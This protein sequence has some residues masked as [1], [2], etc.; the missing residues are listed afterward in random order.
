M[1]KSNNDQVTEAVSAKATTDIKEKPTV[2]KTKVSKTPK[3]VVGNR[4][5]RLIPNPKRR[6]NIKLK[7]AQTKVNSAGMALRDQEGRVQKTL[8]DI[9]DNTIQIPGTTRT[10][11]PSLGPSGLNTGLSTMVDNPYSDEEMYYPEEFERILKGK[12]KVL[13]QHALEYKHKKSIGY[14][15]NRLIDRINPSDKTSELP[16]F[17]T[18]QCQIP[19]SGGVMFLD[20]SNQVHEVWLYTLLASPDIANSYKML[21]ETPDAWY[22]IEDASE[23]ISGRTQRKR[24]ENK[25][26]AALE[27]VYT[28]GNNMI[29]KWAKCLGNAITNLN[30]DSAYSWLDAFFRANEIQYA[31]FTKYYEMFKDPARRDR[32]LANAAVQEYLDKQIIRS[33]E[34]KY[35]WIMP[36]TENT[37]QTTFEWITKDKLVNDFLLAP[38]YA[39]EVQILESLFE[40]RV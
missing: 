30:R 4:K 9:T 36:E 22:Y 24:K 14:Y 11:K 20:L 33:R 7:K 19:L 10:L 28:L 6:T 39:D 8:V 16:F 31:Q 26:V 2:S 27:E 13:L 5:V 25:A 15:D 23:V 12:S 40:A 38:E 18:P 32:F 1:P 29:V 21:D 17:L 35:Y 37:A 3:R 34:G